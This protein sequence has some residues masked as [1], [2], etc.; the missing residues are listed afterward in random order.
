MERPLLDKTI[1]VQDF[2][3]F[4]WRKEELFAFCRQAGIGTSGGKMALAERIRHFL[5]AGTVPAVAIPKKE[6]RQPAFDWHTQPLSGSTVITDSYKNTQNVRAFFTQAIGKRFS[7]NVP[8]MNWMKENRGKTLH[9]AVQEWERIHALKKNKSVTTEIAPQFEYNR[10]MR[11]FL[12]DNPAL[13]TKDAMR[14]WKVK[15]SMR[16]TNDYERKDLE[17]VSVGNGQQAIGKKQ[18]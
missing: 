18:L 6:K 12:A 15:S 10:Y 1:S 4:Y 7:F 9:D 16:G 2:N 11:A 8:F 5:S 13:T 3:D 17:L 14:C